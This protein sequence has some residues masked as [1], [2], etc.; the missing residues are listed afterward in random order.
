[1]LLAYKVHKD[2]KVLKEFKEQQDDKVQQ[3]Q[4]EIPV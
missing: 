2:A 4:Q 3:A 1:V